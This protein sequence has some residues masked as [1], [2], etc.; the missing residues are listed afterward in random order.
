M[1]V[2]TGGCERTEQE[3]RQLFAAHGFRLTRVVGTAI[4]ASVL[5][6]RPV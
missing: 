6:C 4:N 2:L 1:M 5:E 3:Y